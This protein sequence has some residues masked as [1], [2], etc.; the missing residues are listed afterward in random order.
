[1]KEKQDMK[2]DGNRILLVDDDIHILQSIR[3][4]LVKREYL[5]ETAH[6]GETALALFE[7]SFFDLVITDLVMGEV[8]GFQVLETVKKS[9][10]DTMVIIMTGYGEV[11]MVIDCLRLGAD[12]YLLKPFELEELYFRMGKCFDILESRKVKKKA[13]KE[14]IRLISQLKDALDNV[15]RLKGLLPICSSCK[16][17]RDDKGY[18]NRLEAYIEKNSEAQF[19]HSMCPECLEKNLRETRVV[20]QRQEKKGAED[21]SRLEDF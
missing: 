1:M 15:T 2:Q 21:D 19:S 13:E 12:E 14:R 7:K 18:W 4:A 16:K 3:A 10:Q 6:N 17:I 11:N 8:D 20:Y 9:D 5:V